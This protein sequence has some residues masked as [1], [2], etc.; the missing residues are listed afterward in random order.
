MKHR[1]KSSVST[2]F[3]NLA[4]ASRSVA[5]RNPPRFNIPPSEVKIPTG[6]L[7]YRRW[8]TP[9]MQGLWQRS[10]GMNPAGYLR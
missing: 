5:L 3:G 4:S 10:A 1:L 7:R 9:D 2:W 6:Y 8:Q